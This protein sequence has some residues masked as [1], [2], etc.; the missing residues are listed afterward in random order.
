MREV[1]MIMK[2]MDKKSNQITPNNTEQKSGH[3][4]VTKIFLKT[5]LAVTK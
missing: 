1:S 4:K 5:A 2:K 3:K